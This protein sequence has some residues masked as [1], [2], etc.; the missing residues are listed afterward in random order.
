MIAQRAALTEQER[1]FLL[2]FADDTEESPW[3]VASDVQRLAVDG[4]RFPLRHYARKHHPDWYV[5]SELLVL[6]PKP[7]GTQGQVAPDVL[8]AWAPNRLRDSFD[9][10][11]E[12][13]FPAFV[14]EVISPDYSKRDEQDKA[15][16]YGLC[17]VEE[18]AIFNPKA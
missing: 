4:F 6:F 14:L 8:V 11:A 3:M 1:N 7:D 15:R 13:G 18:Y 12:G 16:L 9:S 17:G 2:A 5:S 10:V